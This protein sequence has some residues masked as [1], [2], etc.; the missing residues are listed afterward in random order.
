MRWR[1]PN[2]FLYIRVTLVTSVSDIVPVMCI[3]PYGI[4]TPEND[5]QRD[6]L[7]NSLY[8]PIT[9]E[10]ILSGEKRFEKVFFSYMI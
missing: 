2:R 1:D 3:H 8:F 4:D 6:L 7:N 5:V 10:D 9:K